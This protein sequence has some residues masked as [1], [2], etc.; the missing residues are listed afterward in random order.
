MLNRRNVLLSAGATFALA[1]VANA[2]T[3]P[4]AELNKAFD[5]FFID[6]G[7]FPFD[8]DPP[9]CRIGK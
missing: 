4:E 2:A 1:G 7:K 9:K 5:D 8:V 6:Q 3:G